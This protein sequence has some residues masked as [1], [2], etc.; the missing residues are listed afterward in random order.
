MMRNVFILLFTVLSVTTAT[1]QKKDKIKGSKTIAVTQRK[2]DEFNSIEVEDN[3]EVF[4]VKGNEQKFEIEADDNLHES[5][6][7]EVHG[8]NLRITTNKK[9]TRAKKISVR[10]TYNDALKN[11]VAKHETTLN[12][13]KPL[14]L[15]SI[16]IKNLNYSKSFLNIKVRSFKLEMDDKAEGEINVEASKTEIILSKNAELEALLAVPDV[17]I[18][19]YQRATATIEGDAAAAQIRLDNNAELF[20]KKFTVKN[21]QLLAEGYSKNQV[22]VSEKLSFSAN[23]K[24]ETVLHDM[25]K[26]E[27]SVFADN[28]VLKKED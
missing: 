2:L 12:A 15:D 10:I 1:A 9:I 25:P 16:S 19:M 21:M 13:L 27:I 23:G 26:I 17:K 20:A 5:I 3:I 22:K 7:A 24:S 4:L 6:T 14:E 28:A 8:G 18:D 11:I